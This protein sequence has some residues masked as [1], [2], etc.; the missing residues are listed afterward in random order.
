MVTHTVEKQG[1]VG[2]E[3]VTRSPGKAPLRNKN[4]NG[5]E[6]GRGSHMSRRDSSREPTGCVWT[7]CQ[8]PAEQGIRMRSEQSSG[9][10]QGS[11]ATVSEGH[12]HGSELLEF[13]CG[14]ASVLS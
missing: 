12:G 4:L 3:L 9:P 14:L 7:V 2:A 10:G 13:S 1:L 5:Q 6:G 11:L 8:R